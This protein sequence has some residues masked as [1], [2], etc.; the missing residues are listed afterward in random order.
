MLIAVCS[1]ASMESGA[2]VAG[3]SSGYSSVAEQHLMPQWS[4]IVVT[5]VSW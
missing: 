1:L 5:G 3:V 2:L 4:P